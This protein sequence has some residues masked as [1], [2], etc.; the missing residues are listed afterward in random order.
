MRWL[1]ATTLLLYAAVAGGADAAPVG[2]VSDAPFDAADRAVLERAEAAGRSHVTLLIAAKEDRAASVAATIRNLGGTVGARNNR[3]DYVR[4]RVPLE[5]VDRVARIDAIEAADVDRVIPLDD[6]SPQ[7]SSPTLPQTPPSASTPRTNPYMPLQDTGADTFGAVPGRDGSG[8]KVAIVDAAID[9]SHE[10]LRETAGGQIKIIDRVNATRPNTGDGSWVETSGS[11]RGRFAAN[12]A[13]W[14]AP[15]TGGPYAFGTLIEDKD[16]LADGA[17][18]GDLNRNGIAG[19]AIGVLQNRDTHE[20]IVDANMN[21]DFTD[22]LVL[23]DY[24]IDHEYGFLGTNDPGTPISERGLSYTVDTRRS[25]YEPDD[26]DGSWLNI[27]IP[28]NAHGSH[29]AGIVAANGMFGGAMS[30]NAPGAE[31]IGINACFADG[32]C[33]N[34]GMTEGILYAADAGADVANM[35][36]GGMRLLNATSDAQLEIYDRIVAEYGMA[37]F[38]SAGNDGPG[39]NVVASPSYAKN[40]LSVAASVHR[41]TWLANY[42]QPIATGNALFTF[43]SRGP[44]LDGALKPE[45]TAPGSAISSVPSWQAGEPV[46]GTFPL[47]RGYAMFNGTSMSSPQAAGVAALLISAYRSEFDGRSP[48]P[49]QLRRALISTAEPIAASP[50][51]GQG[52]GLIDVHA[53][54]DFLRQEETVEP[55]TIDVRV[56]VDHVLAGR[57][58][59]PGIGS[60][61]YDREN[62][63]AGDRYTRTLTLTRT[64]GSAGARTF[65]VTHRGDLD[66]SVPETVALPLD[67]PVSMDV[68][69]HAGDPGIHSARIELDDPESHGIDHIV[70]SVVFTARHSEPRLTYSGTVP[71]GGDRS[72]VFRVPHGTSAF[73]VDLDGAGPEPE[74]G[75]LRFTVMDPQGMK[76]ER[77]VS[78]HCFFPDTGA[79]CPTGSPTSRTVKNPMPGVWEVT[80]QAYRASSIQNASFSV[81]GSMLRGSI[82]PESDRIAIREPAERP[83]EYEV[84][85]DGAAFTGHL[86]GGPL[87]A[88]QQEILAVAHGK[89]AFHRFEIP[90]GA[91]ELEVVIDGSHVPGANLDLSLHHCG[92]LSCELVE[93]GEGSGARRR[94]SIPEPK[95]GEYRVAVHGTSVPIGSMELEQWITYRSPE[96][97]ETETGDGPAH[98]AAGE[99]WT[100]DTSVTVDRVPSP[101]WYLT[102]EV[103]LT[104]DQGSP[105]NRSEIAIAIDPDPPVVTLTGTPP[106]SGAGREATF[107]FTVDDPDADSFC[108][109][110]GNEW[111]EC[112]SPHR[113]SGLGIG[114]HRF[115]VRARDEVGFGETV[116]YDFETTESGPICRDIGLRLRLKGHRARPPWGKPGQAPG[117]KVRMKAGSDV[118]VRIAPKLRYRVKGK[119][120]TVGLKHRTVRI[121]GSR[122]FRF[123]LPKKMKRELRRAKQ[124][125]K[126]T[127][128]TVMVKGRIRPRGSD[129]ACDQRLRVRNLRTRVVGVARR[130]ALRRLGW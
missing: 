96:L 36:L 11:H 120:R 1:V 78:T 54:W 28:N 72:V 119:P 55:S 87:S 126:G 104:D 61:I 79:G 67:V 27:G 100:V 97:G 71:R 50:T 52:A 45:I 5:Q 94:V 129:P 42:G 108:R 59:E 33:L 118:T 91:D 37:I 107:E 40:V 49:D 105:L 68:E 85:N 56:P 22:D 125:A 30:G 81:T 15:D 21:R 113:L 4:A 101:G 130:G 124:R 128:V 13:A 51:Y 102:G 17:F 115:E 103:V 48:T 18:E 47:P 69:I 7:G 12:R 99:R 10:A 9:V 84:T 75:Q 23:S 8:V 41:D 74:K 38:I 114:D 26:D 25:E 123:L 64:T 92:P 44:T 20:V 98:R 29:V 127:P 116:G 117:V 83:L 60:G 66:L 57:L 109:L 82:S 43:S 6:P 76:A 77:L 19:E 53:A 86:A 16:D 2:P 111:A 95:A 90:E 62:V 121:N 65:N 70:Q 35:S 106:A 112:A 93:T 32:S 46:P 63:Y 73:R 34:S 3:V 110:D 39:A 122:N 58:K 88:V 31:L 89:D 14:I 24:R 80:V